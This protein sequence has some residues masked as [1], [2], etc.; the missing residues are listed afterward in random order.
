MQEISVFIKKIIRRWSKKY[1]GSIFITS[2][3]KY[4]KAKKYN[5]NSRRRVDIRFYEGIFDFIEAFWIKDNTKIVLN[6]V[7]YS[8]SNKIQLI[9]TL[10]KFFIIYLFI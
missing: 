10:Y 3:N 7:E 9:I 2:K 8:K 5:I 4:E 1:N 6:L